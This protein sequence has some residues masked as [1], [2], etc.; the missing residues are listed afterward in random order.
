MKLRTLTTVMTLLL[1]AFFGSAGASFGKDIKERMKER[2]PLVNDLKAR[3]IVGEN[4][5]GYLEFL[6]SKREKE[7]VVLQENRDREK[8]Y[9]AIAKQQG[10]TVKHVG[11]RRALQIADIAKP[12]D[13]IQD[14]TGTWKKLK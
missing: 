13:W 6:G 10:T 4:N 8:V 2:L 14:K 3:E 12:G 5:K 9:R 7:D 11:E 1:F